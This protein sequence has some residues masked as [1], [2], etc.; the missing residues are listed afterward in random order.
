MPV[1]HRSL[2]T[3]VFLKP[4]AIPL[5]PNALKIFPQP[6]GLLILQSLALRKPASMS[7]S[8]VWSPVGEMGLCEP[9]ESFLAMAASFCMS[10]SLNSIS[11]Y[12][13]PALAEEMLLE[14]VRPLDDD[15]EL[16]KEAALLPWGEERCKLRTTS[17]LQ[18]GHV[19]RRVVNHGVLEN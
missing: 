14:S 16:G 13:A 18:I 19:R 8:C 1:H 4:L 17:P 15:E 3:S 10:S 12:S 7:S 5:P 2:S 9:G 11:L 6:V